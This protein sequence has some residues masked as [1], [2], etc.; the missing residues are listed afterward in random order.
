MIIFPFKRY[1]R[2]LLINFVLLFVLVYFISFSINKK[3]EK[4]IEDI[5]IETINQLRF[6]DYDNLQD[7][8]VEDLKQ[9]T[10]NFE[11]SSFEFANDNRIELFFV[12]ASSYLFIQLL[13]MIFI[14][15]S[16]KKYIL[17]ID[18]FTNS[19]INK[20]F[21][22]SLKENDESVISNINNR[23]NKLG[24]VIKKNYG[25]MN[26]EK[27]KFKSALEDIAHQIKT[28]LSALKMYN[29]IILDSENLSKEQV[30]FLNLSDTQ[31]SRLDWLISSL[32][33]ISKFEA[34]VIELNTT[35]FIISELGQSIKETLINNLK[36]RN[37]T[38][39]E[40][41]DMSKEVNLDFKWTREALLNLVKNATEHAMINSEI[42]LEY[43]VNISIIRIDIINKGNLI[44][45]KDMSKIFTRFYKSSGNTN[46]D[47]V[48]IGLNLSK[49]IIEKQ[50]GTIAVQNLNDGVMFSIIFLK[51]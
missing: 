43:T 49:K 35:K 46:P 4:N 6:Q 7:Y 8:D 22:V 34:D 19:I 15:I 11:Q 31:I 38:I 50:G 12:I 9:I 41:G 45:S 27:I 20:Q 48:G 47:S 26:Q 1:A 25:K 32:L 29:E 37:L 24:M 21:D 10:K 36:N 13:N 39:K 42:I 40:I 23:F 2:L 33:K 3:I 5:Q 44:S 17:S 28:P 16:N 51:F 18:K 30:E 14:A